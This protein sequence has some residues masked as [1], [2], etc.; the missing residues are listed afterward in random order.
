[1]TRKALVRALM[2][3]AVQQLVSDRALSVFFSVVSPIL[4]MTHTGMDDL[5]SSS[6]RTQV[7]LT[8][9]PRLRAPRAPDQVL[10]ATGTASC[11]GR[12]EPSGLPVVG[13]L[14]LPLTT[15]RASRRLSSLHGCL[16]S[17]LLQNPGLGPLSG[18]PPGGPSFT[19]TNAPTGWNTEYCQSCST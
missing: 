3:N 18:F 10:S 9:S 15:P 19:Q 17:H 13:N 7:G 2:A 12:A 14:T 6:D 1:M 8:E 4:Q 11:E 5:R 16:L